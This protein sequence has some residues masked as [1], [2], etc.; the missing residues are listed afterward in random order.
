MCLAQFATC[1]TPINKLP[2]KAEIVVEG[3]ENGCSKVLSSQK[4]FNTDIF[5]PN[6]IQL[7]DGL[8]F[9]RLRA[10]PQVLRIHNSKKKEGH[11]KHYSELLLFAHWRNENEE[12]YEDS[13]VISKE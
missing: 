6:Y 13:V 12:F 8:G 3:F 9:M 10:F 4:I 5:L 11:E 1:Y 7:Q 2:K